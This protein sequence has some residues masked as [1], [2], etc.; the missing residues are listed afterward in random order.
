MT[1]RYQMGGGA[2]LRGGGGSGSG[3]VSVGFSRD[4][5]GVGV[6]GR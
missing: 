4:A 2:V 3:G 1:F 5:T 6:C